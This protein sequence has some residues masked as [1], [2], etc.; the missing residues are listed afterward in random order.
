[1]TTESRRYLCSAIAF[2]IAA[3]TTSSNARLAA[4]PGQAPPAQTA[5]ADISPE[6]LAQIEALIREKD[7]RSG[8]Q[9]KIDSQLIYALRMELGQPI[10]TGVSAQETDLPYA[11]DGHVVVDVTARHTSALFAS[12]TALGVE[13]LSTSPDGG[14]L[15]VHI[16]I[17]QVEALAALP[18]VSFV[19]PKQEAQIHQAVPNVT[20]TQTGQG[21]RSSEGDIT[22][23]A[24]A[25]RAAFGANGSGIKI[26]VL[27]DGVT[28]LAASQA[29][30]DLGPVTVLAG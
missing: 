17:D 29:S 21:S 11:A 1:M 13:V 4:S 27:S 8:T 12:L 6:A 2:V 26:G 20:F 25:A 16:N 5:T 3:A 22:H 24:Y 19:Q 9:R 10:A 15:R 30:G 18:D 14:M 7:V 28:S 23:L